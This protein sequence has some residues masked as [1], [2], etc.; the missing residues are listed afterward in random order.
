MTRSEREGLLGVILM[1]GAV[2]G[3]YALWVT[4][5]TIVEAVTAAVLWVTAA[6]AWLLGVA[7]AAVLF[8][9]TVIFWLSVGSMAV[10]MFGLVLVAY[11]ADRGGLSYEDTE[12]LRYAVIMLCA[13][14]VLTG[15]TY[16]V[17]T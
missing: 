8:T 3:L 4:V 7:T 16:F 17:I 10:G 11:R 5:V 13:G 14:P 2:A 9:A 15:L 6:I 1:I 12:I